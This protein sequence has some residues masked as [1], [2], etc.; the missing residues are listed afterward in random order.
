MGTGEGEGTPSELYRLLHAAGQ[1]IGLTHIAHPQRLTAHGPHRGTLL[2]RLCQQRQGLSDTAGTG[3][4]TTQGRSGLREPEQDVENPAELKAA[5]EHGDGPGE[6]PRAEREKTDTEIRND[7]A[8]WVIDR[9]GDADRFFAM[10]A[11]LRERS[12]LGKAPG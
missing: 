12:Q 8:V 11:R 4:R 1:Q 2:L 9:L 5:F 3:I 7:K 10:G 6:V